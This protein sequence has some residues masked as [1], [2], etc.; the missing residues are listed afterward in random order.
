MSYH[1]AAVN[2]AE[3]SLKQEPPS[4]ENP[5]EQPLIPIE[6]RVRAKNKGNF[7]CGGIVGAGVSGN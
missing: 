2:A 3:F 6:K 4:N 1:N 5:F 7:H